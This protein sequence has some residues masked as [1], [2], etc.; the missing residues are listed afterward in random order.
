MAHVV[1]FAIEDLVGRKGTYAQTLNRDVNIFFGRNGSGKT[2]LLRILHSAMYNDTSIVAHVPFKRA[3]VLI[4]SESVNQDFLYTFERRK[5][6]KTMR[7]GLQTRT[8]RSAGTDAFFHGDIEHLR[9]RRRNWKVTPDRPKGTERWMHSYLGTHRLTGKGPSTDDPHSEELFDLQFERDLERRWLGTFGEIQVRVRE[10]QE[11]GLVDILNDVLTW[12]EPS[13]PKTERLNWEA[14]YGEMVSFLK[15]QNPKSQPSTRESFRRRFEESPLLRSIL[16]HIER[17]EREVNEATA[18]QTKFQALIERLFT[19]NKKLVSGATSIEV[20]SGATSIP[21]RS[22]SSG[23]KQILYI[24]LEAVKIGASSLIIDEPELS[25]HVDWQ[26]EL[27]VAI[28]SLNP[29]T[30]LIFATHSPEIMADV[31]DSRIFR[32]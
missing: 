26:R 17:V 22:L 11:K 16:I 6:S 31:E 1:R 12:K 29:A 4:H 8:R 20:M 14:A 30:Q 27:I 7:A 19:G 25:M 3:E 28:Q 15:R 21:L 10:S 32:V 5:S 23:E 2:S 9:P 18:P 13:Q 24:L